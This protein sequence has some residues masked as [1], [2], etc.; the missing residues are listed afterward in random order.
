MPFPFPG[1]N[2]YL[3]NPDLWPEVHHLLISLLAET[4][5]PQLLPTYRVAIEKRVYQ[6]TGEDAVLIG[7]PDATVGVAKT[8][9]QAETP[10]AIASPPPHPITVT[11]P[12]PVEIKE[13]YLEVREVA[14][15][16]VVTV[17]EVLSPANKRSGRGREVYLQKR[18]VVLASRT[19]L[20]EIDLLRSGSPMPM[21]GT[22]LQHDYQ[23]MVSRQQR[24]PWADLYPFTVRDPMPAFGL[25]LKPPHADIEIQLDLLLQTVVERAGLEVVL[26][27]GRDPVPT[28]TEADASWLNELLKQ[29]GHRK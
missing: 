25:P 6:I 14:T 28:M 19:H 12:I 17:I 18:D 22:E 27:Y 5:N 20:V 8:S 26:N 1:M 11:L 3:E 16:E 29:T 21:T 24:R 7:I 2:P 13:A 9:V 23:I 10:V 4:L 15:Q